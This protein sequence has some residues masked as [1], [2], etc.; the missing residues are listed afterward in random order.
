LGL[1][2]SRA[3]LDPLHRNYLPLVQTHPTPTPTTVPA[4]NQAVQTL[5]NP[6]FSGTLSPWQAS[7]IPW[8]YCDVPAWGCVAYLGGYNYANDWLVQSTVVPGWAETAAVYFDW[9]MYSEDSLTAAY[10]YMVVSVVAGPPGATVEIG[11]FVHD[12]RDDDGT[13]Y[14]SRMSWA[15]VTSLRGQ[16]I[17]VRVYAF[18]DGSYVTDWFVDNVELWFGCG[19]AIAGDTANA[20]ERLDR[21]APLDVPSGLSRHETQATETPAA[22]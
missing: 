21:E 12:N 16:P 1:S 18:S 9:I 22:Y 5:A 13:W 14:I 8:L 7:G 17:S 20:D 3:T 2:A 6:G 11:Q 10:D 19:T 4:C 15:D